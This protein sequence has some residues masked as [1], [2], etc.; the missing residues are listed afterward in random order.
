LTNGREAPDE[1]SGR[2]EVVDDD[3]VVAIVPVMVPVVERC[4]VM[5]LLSTP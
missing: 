1:I 3:V 5:T 4:K 2:S